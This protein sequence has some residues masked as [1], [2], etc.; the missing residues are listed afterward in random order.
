MAD[1]KATFTERLAKQSKTL[2]QAVAEYKRRYGRDPPRGFDHWW[3]FAKE[4]DFK[5]VDEFDAVVEDLAPF[6]TLSGEELRR[7]AFQV[8]LSC[9]ARLGSDLTALTTLTDGA[10]ALNRPRTHQ[11]R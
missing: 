4:H 3:E 10:L 5:L 6:W 1:A 9:S 8:G 2:P 11:G 7:R